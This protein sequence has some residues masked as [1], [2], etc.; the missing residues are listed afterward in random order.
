MLKDILEL[1]QRPVTALESIAVS[2]SHIA[3]SLSSSAPVAAV[4]DNPGEPLVTKN[5]RGRPPRQETPPPAAVPQ[6]A[7][8]EPADLDVT[9]VNETPAPA[10]PVTAG[11]PVHSVS[12]EAI[13][14]L[15]RDRCM[16][17]HGKNIL[18]VLQNFGYQR[19]SQVPE[20]KY[21]ALLDAVKAYADEL[22]AAAVK[23]TPES[24]DDG[25]S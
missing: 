14:G 18:P 17:A 3:D 5:R 12:K 20:D 13:T 2:L 23:T 15:A 4:P 25:L 8:V 21:P 22:D 19:L 11:G 7:P 6:S 10:A 9:T 24:E 16:K 1:L